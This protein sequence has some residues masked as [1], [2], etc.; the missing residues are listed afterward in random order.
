MT[1]YI[2]AY[3]VENTGCL[4]GVREIVKKHE[5]YAMPATFFIVSDLLE[6]AG[7]EY[8]SLLA[9]HPLFEIACPL[10]IMSHVADQVGKHSAE[11][12]VIVDD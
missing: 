10:G 7:A 9:G 11:I 6:T 1:T 4:A 2:A 3:D 8:R 12:P 5:Q